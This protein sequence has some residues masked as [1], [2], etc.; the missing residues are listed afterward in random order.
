MGGSRPKA[1]ETSLTQHQPKHQ[2]GGRGGSDVDDLGNGDGIRPMAH[3]MGSSWNG[4]RPMV[5]G[6]DGLGGIHLVYICT[7]GI[8]LHS[9]II[10][11]Q[12]CWLKWYPIT[13]SSNHNHLKLWLQLSGQQ[14]WAGTSCLVHTHLPQLL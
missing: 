3:G 14:S 12:Q 13:L 6:I 9:C 11:V 8:H 5:H 1:N 7:A 2:W 10:Y 4:I